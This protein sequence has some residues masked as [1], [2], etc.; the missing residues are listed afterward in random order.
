M[1]QRRKQKEKTEDKERVAHLYTGTVVA[2]TSA[3]AA[4]RMSA[5]AGLKAS[6][7]DVTGAARF[8]I[9]TV[10]SCSQYR[11]SGTQRQCD[12]GWRRHHASTLHD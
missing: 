10:P 5:K 2:V 6:T 9:T 4:T 12:D 8:A 3:A 11:D 7:G 1:R